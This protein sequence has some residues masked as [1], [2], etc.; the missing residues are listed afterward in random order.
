VIIYDA[1]NCP[2]YR[3]SDDAAIF[4][5]DNVAAV[6]EVKA[7]LDK[8]RL[9]EASE[10]IAAVKSLAKSETPKWAEPRKSEPLPRIQ[11]VGC[12]FAFESSLTMATLRSHYIEEV[13][14]KGGLGHHTDLILVLDRGILTTAIKPPGDEWGAAFLDTLHGSKADEGLLVGAAVHEMGENSLDA[15]LRYLLLPLMHFRPVVP[16]PGFDWNPPHL[17]DGTV[18]II[19][20]LKRRTDPQRCAKRQK[21][22]MSRG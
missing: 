9:F 17:G 11:T 21:K 16:H 8:A 12:V 4:P 18:Q 13:R 19:G 15:F 2:V 5:N 3:V 6:V 10:N 7:R 20:R 14:S 22:S 1:Y